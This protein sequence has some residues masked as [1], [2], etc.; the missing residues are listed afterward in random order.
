M[1]SDTIWAGLDL[2]LRETHVCLTDETGATIHEETCETSAPAIAAAVSLVGKERIGLIAAEAGSETYVIRKLKED[3]LP[4]A[5]FEARKASKFLALRRN[6]TDASD[7]RGLADLARLGRQ[8]VSRVHLKSLQCERLRTQL[9]MR[10]KLVR[11]RVSTE[12]AIRGRLAFYGLSLKRQSSADLL[13]ERVTSELARLRTSE[14]IDLEDDLTPLLDVCEILRKYVRALDRRLEKAAKSHPVCRRLMDVP[15]VGPICSLSFYSA[16]EDP[17]RFKRAS[18]VA[19]Y[20]GLV[21]RRYQSGGVSY[22]R[23]ITKTGSTMTR[24]HLVNSATVF[25]SRGPKSALKEWSATLRERIGP[26]RAKVAVA[27][28]LAIVLLAMWK[29]GGEFEPYPA[30]RKPGDLRPLSPPLGREVP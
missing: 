14:D 22:T 10:H 19:A 21:P 18:D 28:N 25:S 15:G 5:I 23:G 24:A 11:I 20:L 8:T 4:M 13:R 17:D 3:G 7:A 29:T 26:R 1:N 2:G 30:V 12:N 6:K 16:I 9:V 27:R